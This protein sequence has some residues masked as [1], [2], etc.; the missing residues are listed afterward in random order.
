MQEVSI[1]ATQRFNSRFNTT[2]TWRSDQSARLFQFI[3]VKVTA[4]FE[5]INK[6]L[7]DVFKNER[8][9]EGKKYVKIRSPCDER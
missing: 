1:I 2:Y 8:E 5:K 4:I 7:D 9:Y 6:P 3:G